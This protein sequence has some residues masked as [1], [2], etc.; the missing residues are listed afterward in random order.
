M[1]D[2]RLKR[3]PSQEPM[4]SYMLRNMLLNVA[5]PVRQARTACFVLLVG[6]TLAAFWT[7]V[8][9]LIRFSFQHEQYSH[10]ILIPLIS[11]SLLIR[12]RREIFSHLA[13]RWREGLGLLVV[14]ALLYSLGQR[15]SA[16]AS[17]NDRLSV[18]ILAV[19]LTWLGGFVLCYGLRAFRSGLFP[20]LF[21]FLM[22]PIPDFLL[23][24]VI[25]WLQTGSAEV[26]YA[27]FELVGVPVFRAGFIFSLPGVTIE[28]AKECSGIRSSLALLITSLLAGHFFLRS[29]WTKV[30]LLLAALPLLIIKNGI[31]I[32]TLSLLSVYVDPSFLTGRLHHQ[33][34]AV[35]FLIT[36]VLLAPVLRL[37]ERAE[38]T[39]SR[40]RQKSSDLP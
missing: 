17:E 34:G 23:N 29:A 14:G 37:L 1:S 33:G 2:F 28:V 13:T 40:Y 7:P 24:R 20:L 3:S 39:G 27:A 30:L 10:I 25:V 16:S 12:K 4:V 15:H 32:V 22:V 36:L 6:L 21:L 5:H 18:A 35:F 38:R 19:I 26:S 11:A 31:R 8:T 9:M